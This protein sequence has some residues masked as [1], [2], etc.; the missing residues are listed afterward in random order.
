MLESSPPE[1]RTKAQLL[2]R[3]ASTSVG[4]MPHIGSREV[5]F[6]GLALLT[7]WI[8]QMPTKNGDT[9]PTA[10][11]PPT[12]L[13]QLSSEAQLAQMQQRLRE[14]VQKYQRSPNTPK[15]LDGSSPDPDPGAEFREDTAFT[16]RE[17]ALPLA[18][19]AARQTAAAPGTQ[20][21]ESLRP[22]VKTLATTMDTINSSLFE[23][24]L[25]PSER[26][27]RLR[28]NA[29]FADIAGITG[30]RERG[31]VLFQTASHLQ[32]AKCHQPDAS[33]RRLGPDL[34]EIGRRSSPE[35][36]FE[37]IVSPDR[38][39]EPQYQSRIVITNSGR[40][41]VGLA[42]SETDSELVLAAANGERQRIP[43]SEIESQVRDTKSLMPSGLAVQLTA[44]DMA[45]LLAWLSSEKQ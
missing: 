22:L 44:Q 35:Q 10:A 6:A 21:P 30:N 43:A 14:H 25:P 5:D 4:R 7:D 20:L 12:P 9:P 29:V 27:R 19:I 15:R 32:C 17:F 3:V 40:S 41:L 38:R 16:L 31:K 13:T 45:D 37:S 2:Y 42:E 28:P 11:T 33:G 36:L 18:Q 8:A 34:S 24:H 23:A 1:N 39:I 26:L